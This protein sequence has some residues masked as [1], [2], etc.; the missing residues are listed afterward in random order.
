M[1]NI[2]LVKTLCTLLDALRPRRAGRYAELIDFVRDRPGHDRRYAMDAAKLRGELGWRP[3]ET[4]ASGLKKTVAW[5]LE[6]D[7]WVANV[8]S[9]AYRQWMEKNYAAR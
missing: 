2:D 4:F 3:S 6:N 5:Y 8:T 7:A 1:T 9:G